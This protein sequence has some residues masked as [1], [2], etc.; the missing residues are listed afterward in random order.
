MIHQAN[1]QRVTAK[2]GIAIEQHDT[3]GG[4]RAMQDGQCTIVQQYI[5]QLDAPGSKPAMHDSR[6]A[7]PALTSMY[8]T[9]FNS[10][11]QQAAQ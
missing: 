7:L 11:L 9:E 5:K 2:Q 10:R 1:W 6:V 4:K 3:P 8:T